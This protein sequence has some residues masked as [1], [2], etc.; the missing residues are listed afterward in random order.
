MPGRGRV[1]KKLSFEESTLLDKKFDY[2]SGWAGGG[3]GLSG[4]QRGAPEIISVKINPYGVD[5]SGMYVLAFRSQS[6]NSAWYQENPS[7]VGTNVYGHQ[8]KENQ[9]D[10]YMYSERWVATDTPS[11]VMH[12]YLPSLAKVTSLRLNAHYGNDAKPTFPGIWNYGSYFN[13]RGPGRRDIRISTN[14]PNRGKDT[15]WTLG[16]SVAPD[17]DI[18]YYA[19]P[20]LCG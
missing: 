10:F 1:I 11:V 9:D 20:F 2:G 3:F 5:F 7:A 12:V 13:I 18:Q 14:A 19:T 8:D 15:W 17:G 4:T 16:I 6:R